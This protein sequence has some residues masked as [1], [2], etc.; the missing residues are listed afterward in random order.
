[1][2][3]Y[4]IKSRYFSVSFKQILYK[5]YQVLLTQSTFLLHKSKSIS[6]CSS[7]FQCKIS[8]KIVITF[9][10]CMKSSGNLNLVPKHIMTSL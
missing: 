10:N 9:N 6:F 8:P 7:N 4:S 5:E 3:K 1:M 2:S